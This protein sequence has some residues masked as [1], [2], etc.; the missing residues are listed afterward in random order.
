M[1]PAP[2]AAEDATIV[3]RDVPLGRAA[4]ALT[5]GQPSTRF[6]LVGLHWR[7]PRHRPV[8]DTFGHGALERL[9]RRG[10]RGRGSARR[11]HGRARPSE[12]VAAREPLVGRA[13]GPD[14]VPP[15]WQGHP[16]ARL[17][18]LEPTRWGA[19]ANAP[20][21]RLARDRPPQRLERGREDQAQHPRLRI[22]DQAR[23]RAPHG[24][25]QRVHGSP[26]TRDRAR[27]RALPREGQRLERHRLQLPRRPLRD[28]FRGSLRRPRAQRHR[29]ARRG[30]QHRVG[31]RRRAGR[32]QLSGRLPAGSGLRSR[33]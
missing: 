25:R 9:G 15:P 27:D 22:R 11:R 10:P 13:V 19:R 6:N 21:G 31:R 18:R 17:L 20:E 14:R 8:Q 5:A 4:L 33:S 7:G 24:R 30:L 3:S 26:V 23:D 2:A 29:R 32:V 28:G 16:L 1:L 12:L